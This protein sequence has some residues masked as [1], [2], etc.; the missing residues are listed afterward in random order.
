MLFETDFGQLM[1]LIGGIT[2]VV[3]VLALLGPVVGVHRRIRRAK[4]ATMAWAN[5]ELSTRLSAFQSP[6][7]S[8]TS[9]EVADLVVYRSLVERVPEWPF[10]L[11]TYTRFVLYLLIPLFFWGIGI[12]AE[13][14][15]QRALS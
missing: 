15:V 7:G 10:T 11:S 8:I 14:V 4:G 6:D 5:G 1:V 3:A 13:E 12:V 2:F 9:G